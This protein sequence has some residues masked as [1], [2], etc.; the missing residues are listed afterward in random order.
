[1]SSRSRQIYERLAKYMSTN[2]AL[3]KI[4]SFA[5]MN[6]NAFEWNLSF[7][8]CFV[9]A[10]WKF[11][12][13]LDVYAR[14]SD[15]RCWSCY[16]ANNN[17]SSNRDPYV[18]WMWLLKSRI[19]AYCFLF[20]CKTIQPTIYS[21]LYTKPDTHSNTLRIQIIISHRMPFRNGELRG[22]GAHTEQ[23]WTL[24]KF[25]NLFGLLRL[26]SLEEERNRK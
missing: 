1:M 18:M 11:F 22:R 24:D 15:S 19:F 2:W 17:N 23:T 14:T 20:Y 16:R 10:H 3:D 25:T 13:R 6:S 8:F 7:W 26:V 9:F 5:P 4:N 21:L 12:V